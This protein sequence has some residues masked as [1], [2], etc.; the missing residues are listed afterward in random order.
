MEVMDPPYNINRIGL[1]F[2]SKWGLIKSIGILQSCRL[3]DHHTLEKLD[4]FNMRWQFC[5]SWVA[6]IVSVSLKSIALKQNNKKWIE[7]SDP[8]L[9]VLPSKFLIPSQS[10]IIQ[11]NLEKFWKKERKKWKKKHIMVWVFPHVVHIPARD[12]CLIYE[13]KIKDSHMY[14]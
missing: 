4:K 13:S 7:C 5:Q 2:Q 14:R 3:T 8:P 1:S 9:K 12:G 10:I 11:G 6:K